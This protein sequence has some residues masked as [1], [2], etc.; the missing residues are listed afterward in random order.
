MPAYILA[1]VHHSIAVRCEVNGDFQRGLEACD[2]GLA[3]AKEVRD[4]PLESE[5]LCETSLL[6][7]FLEKYAIA[8]QIVQEAI[9][10]AR[11]LGLLFMQVNCIRVAA[12]ALDGLCRYR[13]AQRLFEEGVVILDALGLKPQHSHQYQRFLRAQAI[14]YTSKS[15]FSESRRIYQDVV[16]AAPQDSPTSVNAVPGETHARF[17]QAMSMLNVLYAEVVTDDH[18]PILGPVPA[19][20]AYIRPMF[21][22]LDFTMALFECDFVLAVFH[23]RRGDYDTARPLFEALLTQSIEV[24][25]DAN[26]A[27]CCEKLGAIAIVNGDMVGASR[28]YSCFLA[29]TCRTGWLPAGTHRSLQCMGDV[30]LARGDEDTALSLFQV[31]LDG[32]TWMDVHQGVC[33]LLGQARC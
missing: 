10:I 25:D 33:L 1:E 17:D 12:C 29:V 19:R 2:K 21:V 23:M 4:L 32:F 28:W 24:S 5:F 16:D 6:H 15:E 18:N 14:T 13:E 8:F 7:Y 27:N 31:A 3:L 11:E 20:L 30:F 26:Y 9:T 22:N